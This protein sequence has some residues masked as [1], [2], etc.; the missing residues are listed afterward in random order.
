MTEI[1][2]ESK[3]TQFSGNWFVFEE[4]GHRIALWRSSW[5]SMEK[6][7]VD[8][9]WVSNKRASGYQRWH[10]F[11]RGADAYRLETR[12]EGFLGLHR[13]CSLFKNGVMAQRKSYVSKSNPTTGR[14][15]AYLGVLFIWMTLWGG[16]E[17]AGV[18]GA[19][20]GLAFLAFF[21]GYLFIGNQ[22]FVDSWWVQDNYNAKAAP[23]L[24]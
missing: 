3:C 14:F 4:Q 13:E 22:V 5:T 6:V 23:A 11:Q 8:G 24:L 20:S 9:Q 12:S 15:F 1:P 17:H 2:N 19:N 7:W 16:L 10:E 21:I 18:P